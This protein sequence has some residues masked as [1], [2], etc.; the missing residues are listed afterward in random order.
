M[1]TQAP[2][3]HEATLLSMVY[4]PAC[5]HLQVFTQAVPSAWNASVGALMGKIL[6]TFQGSASAALFLNLPV[7]AKTPFPPG[8]PLPPSALP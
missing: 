1:G 7:E 6:L 5:T 3:A 4:L 8:L 2:H